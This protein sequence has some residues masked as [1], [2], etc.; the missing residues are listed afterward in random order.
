MRLLTTLLPL[1]VVAGL[2]WLLVQRSRLTA[3]ERAELTNLR[4]FK[5]RVRDAALDELEVDSSAPFARIVLDNVRQV[6]AA[7]RPRKE[8]S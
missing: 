6:D 3:Q 8:L 2:V 7:N 4:V 1:L 5:D